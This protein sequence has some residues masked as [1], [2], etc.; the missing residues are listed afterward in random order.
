MALIRSSEFCLRDE[1]ETGHAPYFLSLFTIYVN[2][3]HVNPA[4]G[5]YLALSGII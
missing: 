4:A 5:T 2:V 3:K 1:L